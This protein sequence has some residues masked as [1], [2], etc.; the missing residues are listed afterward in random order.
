MFC[1]VFMSENQNIL[2]PLD[3]LIFL[4][5]EAYPVLDRLSQ[6]LI[7]IG[8][9]AINY[10]LTYYNVIEKLTEEEEL[11]ATSYDIDYCG[12]LDDFLKCAESWNV[13][14]EKPSID[15]NSPELGHSLL[16][17]IDTN[18]IKEEDG[19]LFID[20]FEYLINKN[21]KANVVDLLPIPTGFKSIDFKSSRLK[22]HTIPFQFPDII[23]L[24]PHPNL[25]IL[26]P[27]GCL[28]S[29]IQN[30]FKLRAVKNPQV[31]LMRIKLL[32]FPVDYF[33]SEQL[34]NNGYR[35]TRPFIQLLMTMAKT[36]IGF[37]LAIKHGI[38]LSLWL[39]NIIEKNNEYFP[40]QFLE[41]EF[42]FW[43]TGYVNKLERL[44]LIHR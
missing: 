35:K 7:V 13:K 14:F 10:W 20:F 11:T 9:Q 42:P 2:S 21:K 24:E 17:N 26:N 44:Q 32:S 18:Q 22:Q 36:R 33:I 12:Q 6:P 30:L 28:K 41:K 34:E 37:D 8:G 4:N 16:L 39:S 25:L 5:K 23:E 43:L 15:D 27:I 31:E 3:Q 29:R 38:D 1:E 40:S 19:A